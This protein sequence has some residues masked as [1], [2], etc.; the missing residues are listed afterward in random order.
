MLATPRA[1]RNVSCV[2]LY[3]ARVPLLTS[4]SV[5]HSACQRSAIDSAAP[6]VMRPKAPLHSETPP[7]E[8]QNLFATLTVRT[9]IWV[10]PNWT[11]QQ[12][13][14]V[15]TERQERQ[16]AYQSKL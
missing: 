6:Q 8:N 4:A 7:G 16:I 11:L 15:S 10:V 13:M 9:Y 3:R 1:F 14:S 12:S 5:R 2:P